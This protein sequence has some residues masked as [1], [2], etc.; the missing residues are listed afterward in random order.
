MP[1]DRT[2]SRSSLQYSEV[3]SGPGMAPWVECYW[4]IR[5]DG[6]SVV[7]NRV[8]PD[9][10][11]DLIAGIAELAGPAVVGTMRTAAVIPVTGPVDL[12]GIRFRPGAASRFLGMPLGELT[13]RRI[14]LDELWGSRAGLV[15]D[16]LEREGIAARAAAAERML[17]RRLVSAALTREVELVERAVRLLRRARGGASVRETAAALGIGERKLQR[18]FDSAVGLGP[19]ALARV[20]RFR[21]A[22]AAIG[23][24][25]GAPGPIPWAG[26]ALDAGYADQPHF[27]REFRRL[28]GVTPARY[29][30][31]Q[32]GVGFVQYGDPDGG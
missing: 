3:P 32:A 16:L 2:L 15:A 19:K 17:E 23:M 12:F 27:I 5:T 6:P 20:L 13:D 29:A 31:E 30:A 9:G 26:I 7:P 18:A 14:P 1:P 11:A 4:S 8:L 28:A 21:R 10:C 22:V 25:R 24:A